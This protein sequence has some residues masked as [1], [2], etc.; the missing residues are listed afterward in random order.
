MSR[1]FFTPSRARRSAYAAL[2]AERVGVVPLAALEHQA[3]GFLH[4]ARIGIAA[5][6]EGNR[7][8]MRAENEMN[9]G[10]IG[11]VAE[12]R[13]DA[14]GERLNIERMIVE[15]FDRVH[16]RGVRGGSGWAIETRPFLH[17]AD[18]GGERILRI[19][20]EEDQIVQGR[21]A[22]GG[23][24]FA[25]EG[26]PIA[27][28]YETFRVAASIASGGERALEG[29]SL[30]LG[31]QANWGTAADRG[32]MI[33]HDARAPVRDPPGERA[34]RQPRAGEINNVGI[35]KKIVEEWLDRVGRVGATQLEHHYADALA[36]AHAE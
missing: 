28:G 29:S 20:R 7:Q 15:F 16:F 25:R 19:E 8:A 10:G 3:H 2:I 18:G 34:A 1:S 33:G 11:E 31:E 30:A 13:R 22:D 35:A 5:I 27:H 14:F 24:G 21:G 9:A 26:M 23:D 4:L 32:V 12:A 36:F 6:D 17:A